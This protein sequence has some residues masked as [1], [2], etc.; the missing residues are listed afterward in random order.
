MGSEGVSLIDRLA[1]AFDVRRADDGDEPGRHQA[2]DGS[3]DQLAGSDQPE[4]PLALADLSGRIRRL[5]TSVEA[6]P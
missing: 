1:A 4:Q 6:K 3:G 2:Q 5:I